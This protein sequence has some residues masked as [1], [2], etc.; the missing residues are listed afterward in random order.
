MDE[1]KLASVV[2]DNM[3]FLKKHLSQAYMRESIRF[4]DRAEINTPPP[5]DI[6]FLADSDG[7]IIAITNTAKSEGVLVLVSVEENGIVDSGFLP[8][9]LLP[10]AR[11]NMVKTL[12]A[13]NQSIHV[14]IN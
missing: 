5:R 1:A 9:E 8:R 4:R 7:R 13:W 14:A 12:Q 11:D 6:Y 2:E 10:H 3:L